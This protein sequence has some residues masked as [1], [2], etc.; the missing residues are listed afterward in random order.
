MTIRKIHSHN[1]S[2]SRADIASQYDDLFFDDVAN[3]LLL[4]DPTGLLE[5][6][7]GATSSG[8]QSNQKIILDN[9][10]PDKDYYTAADVPQWSASYA[11]VGGQV[12][13]RA[14][15]TAWTQS[16]GPKNWYLKRNGVTVDT[17]QFYFNAVNTH[18]TLPPIQY[19]DTTGA[20]TATWSIAVGTGVI[21]D[22]QDRATITV[23]EYVGI[24]N[25]NVSALSAA[26]NVSGA[27]LVSTNAAGDEGGGGRQQHLAAHAGVAGPV[28]PGGQLPRHH[29]GLLAPDLRPGP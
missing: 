28:R 26:S 29:H 22:T 6:K 11:G 16:A 20:G 13:V 12:L 21:A 4:P 18:T 9:V 15:V 19:V 1:I 17:G 8:N 7:I 23:T 24:S 25:L 5:T 14:D 27:Y 2:N 3:S 10:A